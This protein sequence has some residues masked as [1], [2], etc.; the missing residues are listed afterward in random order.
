MYCRICGTNERVAFRKGPRMA[1]CV[2]C[3]EGTPRKASREGFDKVYWGSG[4]SKVTESVK[5]EFYGDYKASKHTVQ[6]YIDVTTIELY[7]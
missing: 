1:L 7:E 3:A 4:A 2:Y 5:R 6:E